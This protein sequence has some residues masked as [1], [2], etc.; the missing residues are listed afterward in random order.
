MGIP[1]SERIPVA[2]EN[3]TNFGAIAF[4]LLPTA[5]FLGVM[6]YM[7]SRA[8]GGARGGGPGGIFGIGK[9]K[10]RLFNQ[11]TDV[12]VKFKDVAGMNYLS[13]ISW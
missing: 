2:F 13:V 5:L 11:E 1:E 4:S 7:S 6:I 9:S 10:A 12:K 3:P 8:M